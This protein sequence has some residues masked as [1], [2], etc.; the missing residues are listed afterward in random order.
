MTTTQDI[1]RESV[2]PD[3]LAR[4]LTAPSG[5]TLGVYA[6]GSVHVGDS[7][8]RE[9]DPDERPIAT[10]RCPGIGNADMTY[11][12][13]GWDCDGMDDE[14]VI[15]DCCENGDVSGELE[16]LVAR[17]IDDLADDEG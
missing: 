14:E 8:G 13:E 7:I 12:R 11:F 6:D 4:Y 5:W 16:D 15:R 10:A 17:L 1:I 3:E 2:G 9:I